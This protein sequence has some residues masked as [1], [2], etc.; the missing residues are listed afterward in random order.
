MGV[1][2][3][4]RRVSPRA[5]PVDRASGALLIFD[6]VI[7]GFRVAY[8]GAQSLYGVTP[9]ITCLGKIIGG[10]LPVGA[11]GGRRDIME[12]VAPLGP[13]YQAG[14]LSGNPLAVAAG[15]ATLR[16][17]SRPGTYEKLESTC[18]ARAN[19]RAVRDFWAAFG[20]PGNNKPGG[21]GVLRILQ[22]GS[23]GELGRRG[24]VGHRPIP[25]V[26]PCHAGP[27]GL[28]GPVAV[29]GRVRLAGAHGA[30]DTPDADGRRGGVERK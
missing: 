10:G 22:S 1:V 15:I 27:R 11:Y 19:R 3:A 25:A 24:K 18:P 14:T 30:R 4:S 9:D 20:S 8:G 23:G 5:A 17:L 13:M 2:A 7:T 26:L 28:L 6:E 21:V 16:E 12:M 29:R